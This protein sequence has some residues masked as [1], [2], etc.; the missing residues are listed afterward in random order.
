[1]PGMG[2]SEITTRLRN[3]AW[4]GRLV[5]TTVM[6]CLLNSLEPGAAA[7]PPAKPQNPGVAYFDQHNFN[8]ATEAFQAVLRKSPKDVEA[9]IY[10]GRIAFEENRLEEAV[11]YFERATAAAPKN[12]M[13]YLWLGRANGIQARDLGAPRGIGPA[14]RARKN[15]E[16][17]VALD[18]DN[19]EARLDL[20]TY[21]REAP[22]I[23]GGNNRAAALQ[24]EEIKR[25]DPYLGWLIAGDL[26]AED[27]KYAVAERAYRAAMDLK[28]H[29]TESY[30]RFGV[31]EQRLGRFDQAFGAFEKMLQI[32]PNDKR[33]YF[34]IGKTAD[35]S[36]QKLD[37]GE[38]ALK[39]YCE[40]KPFFMMPKLCWAHRRLGNIY[41]QKG[42]PNA[43]RKE[44][45]VALSMDPSDKEASAAL[46]RLSNGSAVTGRP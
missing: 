31:L 38:E 4:L 39:R 9:L 16:K 10:L 43:A 8:A 33:A 30:F 2:R 21:Y 15:L 36:G 3:G 6:A 24:A 19:V 29:D 20:A 32:D 12:S 25:R 26:A 5:M 14:R 23:V 41:L 37:Q 27:K 1:M 28:P 11:H 42:Q 34:Q 13:A 17:A 22:M 35:M 18:P 46:D 44:Y 7:D 40:V 45:L